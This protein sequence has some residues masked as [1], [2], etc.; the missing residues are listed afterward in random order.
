MESN[1]A[2]PACKISSEE[3]RKCD[4]SWLIPAA[5]VCAYFALLLFAGY[6]SRRLGIALI[7]CPLKYLTGIPCPFCGGTRAA[8]ALLQ[9]D[10][11]QAVMMN[12]LAAGLMLLAPLGALL[13]WRLI[14]PRG[15]K[16]ARYKR[17]FLILLI[18]A[19]A[20]NWIYLIRVGR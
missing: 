12:P 11:H 3:V 18:A 6:L 2:Q 19:I 15:W 10:F 1:M 9:G 20:A 14:V 7:F 5:V 13:Y 17:L 8:L 4:R 16:I